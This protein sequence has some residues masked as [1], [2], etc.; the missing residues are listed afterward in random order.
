MGPTA[1]ADTASSQ[2]GAASSGCRRGDLGDRAELQCPP[3]HHRKACPIGQHSWY[4]VVA[5]HDDMD[6]TA[7]A[8]RRA[9]VHWR[10]ASRLPLTFRKHEKIT[11]RSCYRWPETTSRRWAMWRR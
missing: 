4:D 9:M 2:G 6:A 3:Q 10:R 7:A 5:E 8:A 1:Q 11:S